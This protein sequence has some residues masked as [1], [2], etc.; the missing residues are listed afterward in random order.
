MGVFAGPEIVE[1]G[2]VLCL[3]AGNTKSYPGSGITWTDLSGRGNDGTLDGA[4]YNSSNGG[5]ISFDGTDDYVTTGF[6]R[7]TLGNYLTLTAW[8]KYTGTSGRT[9]SAI[10]GGLERSTEF[11]IGKNTGNTNIGVQ[12]GNYYS[13]FVTGS[14]AFDGNWHQIVYSY[15]NGTGK[16]YLDGVLKNTNS[17]TKCNDAEEII[18][19]GETE[20]GGYYFDGNISLVSFYN[21][22]LTAAE[23]QQNFN[24]NRSRFGI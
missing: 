3:D 17:F 2:L 5:S 23:I 8:Y 11:F 21:R 22:V 12:D 20:S 24:A 1:D 9:Y 13:D 6:T 4:G 19:G 18:I 7:G 14:N 16:I 15:D 10:I